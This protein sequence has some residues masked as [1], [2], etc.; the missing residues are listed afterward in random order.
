MEREIVGEITINGV[1]IEHLGHASF[2]ISF[3]EQ[4]LYIDPF[5]KPED[6]RKSELILATH[7]HFDHCHEE[8]IREL[9][10]DGGT[11]VVP[12]GCANM[13]EGLEA[14]IVEAGD[15]FDI[16]N[17]AI[18][19][20]PAYNVNKFRE[21]GKPF[22]PKGLGVGYLI[23]INKVAIYHAGDTDFIP[24]MKTLGKID[25]ALLPIGGHFTMDYKE[26]A[27]AA[28]VIKPKIVVPMHYS[29]NDKIKANPEDFK[30]LVDKTIKVEII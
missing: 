14:K 19:V 18:R 6:A 17:I 2:R 5:V 9:L 26:A 16:D 10:E 21:P 20:V 22:H 3:E 12:D 13:L 11:V 23:T 4:S 29:S 25:V 30:K 8:N 28:N 27:A 1:R 15:E 7:E 24:E